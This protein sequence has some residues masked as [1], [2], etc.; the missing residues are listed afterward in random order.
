MSEFDI[1]DGGTIVTWSIEFD[2]AGLDI[3]CDCRWSSTLLT[4][5]WSME[6]DIVDISW[7]RANLLGR[8]LRGIRLNRTSYHWPKKSRPCRREQ[9][10]AVEN[11]RNYTTKGDTIELREQMRSDGLH[12]SRRT[13]Y[14][15]VRLLSSTEQPNQVEVCRSN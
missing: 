4:Y 1:V 10:G 15:K 12:R 2:I 11:Y 6:F 7:R 14:E 3:Q 13:R 5:G 8:M 9:A